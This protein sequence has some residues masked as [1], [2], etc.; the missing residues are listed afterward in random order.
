MMVAEAQILGGGLDRERSAAFAWPG[1]GD[2]RYHAVSPF[3]DSAC[4]A[5]CQA[6]PRL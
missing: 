3:Q 1:I 2:L 4:R 6:R 5:G